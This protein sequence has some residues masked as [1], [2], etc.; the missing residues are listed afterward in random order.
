MKNTKRNGIS[1]SSTFNRN[2]SGLPKT[3]P[4]RP[5]RDFLENS[6]TARLTAMEI[7]TSL[8]N[9]V[10][11][12][13]ML[14]YLILSAR[15]FKSGFSLTYFPAKQHSLFTQNKERPSAV[16]PI[17]IEIFQRIAYNGV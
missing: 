10:H 16:F 12:R 8:P 2:T 17:I 15:Y 13:F 5:D 3:Y 7:K 14:F 9:S 4:P 1:V 6:S 11:S